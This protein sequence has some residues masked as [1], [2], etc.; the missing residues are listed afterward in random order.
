MTV[1]PAFAPAST[2]RPHW[3]LLGFEKSLLRPTVQGHTVLGQKLI[4]FTHNK[5]AELR[6]VEEGCPHR[7][8]SMAR[9][10]VRGSC[11]VCPFHGC[12]VSIT[13]HPAKFYDHA[14][15]QGL[16]W[17]DLGKD[18]FSQHHM[19]PYYPDF[20]TSN[21]RLADFTREIDANPLALMEALLDPP[22]AQ[23]EAP[24][25]VRPGPYGLASWVCGEVTIEREYHVPFTATT[26]VK[27]GK[28]T[29]FLAMFS[30]APRSTGR[31]SMHVR[32]AR[33]P[34]PCPFDDAAFVWMTDQVVAAEV[35][36]VD[37]GKWGTNRL[38]TG[39]GLV[40]AYR[41]AMRD[42]YPELLRF[43]TA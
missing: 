22:A 37:I 40:C 15:L 16:V 42:Q 39:D 21:Y 4:T 32:T 7:G 36:D 2:K 24:S 9:G 5:S 34:D 6:V 13:Q 33:G 19:P 38:G 10:T 29:L 26:R 20:N 43:L 3:V 23:A 11:L 8:A 27:A 41:Q 14:V 12:A 28:K 1:L 31:V 25:S 30:L 35:C 18:I 17:V